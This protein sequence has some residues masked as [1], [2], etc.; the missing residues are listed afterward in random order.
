MLL[1]LFSL[2]NVKFPE[3][4][5]PLQ[6]RGCQAVCRLGAGWIVVAV[7]ELHSLNGV[8]WQRNVVFFPEAESPWLCPPV[9]ARECAGSALDSCDVAAIDVWLSM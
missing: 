5:S 4:E 1:S 9:A 6:S 2:R 8:P 7:I 3:A